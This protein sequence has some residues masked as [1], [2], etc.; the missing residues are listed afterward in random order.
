MSNV[1][2]FIAPTVDATTRQ[3]LAGSFRIRGF[4]TTDNI[5]KATLII[6][7]V[8][9]PVKRM[10]IADF[11]EK[12][13]SEYA[14]KIVETNKIL[15]LNQKPKKTKSELNMRHPLKQFNQTKQT[16]KQRIFNRTNHK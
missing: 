14:Q 10:D 13:V 11:A 1:V 6:T 2:V 9:Q 4:D 8:G 16:Y 12:L 15:L 3:K 7:D 5:K